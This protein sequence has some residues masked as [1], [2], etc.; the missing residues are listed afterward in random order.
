MWH[1]GIWIGHPL[2]REL[3]R[4]GLLVSFDNRYT[5]RGTFQELVVLL[6]Y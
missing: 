1:K 2:R 3:T 4:E 5:T 6:V